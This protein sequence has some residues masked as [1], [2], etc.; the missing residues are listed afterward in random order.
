MNENTLRSL[1]KL[2]IVYHFWY[3]CPYCGVKYDSIEAYSKDELKELMKK[4]RLWDTL[5]GDCEQE[6]FGEIETT[7]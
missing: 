5:C 6:L 4:T 3:Y 7:L 2:E 1:G